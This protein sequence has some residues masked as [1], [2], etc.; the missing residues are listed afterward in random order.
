M[1][2]ALSFLEVVVHEN[3]G[4]VVVAWVCFEIAHQHLSSI[5]GACN[6]NPGCKRPDNCQPLP[7]NPD[8]ES[9]ATQEDDAKQACQENDGARIRLPAQEQ[10]E[11]DRHGESRG[12]ACT[13]DEFEVVEA[14]VAP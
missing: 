7:E 10:M 11:H 6:E 13:H 8:C 1:D 9:D 5:A 3:D 2:R 4:F 14:D 12:D